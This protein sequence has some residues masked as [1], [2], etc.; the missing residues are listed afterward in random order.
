MAQDIVVSKINALQGEFE[1]AL[2]PQLPSERFQRI[3]ITTIKT[4]PELMECF[5]TPEGQRSIFAESMKAAQDGIIPDGREGALVVFSNKVKGD[6]GK[7][8]WVKQ[9]QYMP[10]VRGLLRKARNS[11][12]IAAFNEPQIVYSKDS[13]TYEAGDNE[14]L[15]HKPDVFCPDRGEPIGAYAIAKLKNGEIVRAVMPKS[16]IMKRKEVSKSAGS[17]FSPWVQWEM[18]MWKKTVMK[19]L[20][21][22][23]PSSVDLNAVFANDSSMKDITPKDGSYAGQDRPERSAFADANPDSQDAINALEAEYEE[24]DEEGEATIEIADHTGEITSVANMEAAKEGILA[25]LANV[26]VEKAKEQIIKNNL[27]L[28]NQFPKNDADEIGEAATL[29][30]EGQAAQ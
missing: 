9:A 28:I 16:D 8:K 23:L 7:D 15:E 20:I 5:K 14:V 18:E 11:D 17:K 4:S 25:F 10:M 29:K 3:L 12:E 27:D 30:E 1:K 21:K 22:Y 26:P 6:H 24:V 13:F 2:P 19:Q